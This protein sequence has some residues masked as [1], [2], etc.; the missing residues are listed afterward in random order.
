MVRVLVAGI[1]AGVA[2]FVWGFVSWVVLD[3]H[4]RTF[5]DLPNEAALAVGLQEQLPKTKSKDGV[6]IPVSGAY[7][8]PGVEGGRFRAALAQAKTAEERK[9]VQDERQ[10]AEME[11][12]ERH[13]DGPIATIFYRHAGH[14]PM[15]P[16]TLAAGLGIAMLCGFFAALAVYI[17]LPGRPN[18][19]LRVGLVVAMGCFAVLMT[20]AIEWDYL[21]RPDDY[22]LV[23]CA[24]NLVGSLV[25]GIVVALIVR[26]RPKAE[27]G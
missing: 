20:Y 26:P 7:R 22:T 1:V 9:K 2:L 8:I 17:A 4:N 25:V 16:Q 3:W 27:T 18:F 24:D 5:R 15:A 23:M 10:A 12:F 21:Y 13:R 19:L 6:P 14:E 11:M